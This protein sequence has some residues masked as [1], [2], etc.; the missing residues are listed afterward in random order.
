MHLHILSLT[1]FTVC[2]D[3]TLLSKAEVLVRDIFH[4]A[5]SSMYIYRYWSKTK[6]AKSSQP[7]SFNIKEVEVLL[8]GWNPWNQAN[9]IGFS[10]TGKNP[11]SKELKQ[12]LHFD[13]RQITQRLSSS[14]EEDMMQVVIITNPNLAF[15]CGRVIHH[16]YCNKLDFH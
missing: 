11:N 10:S 7:L 2:T 14:A 9:F 8:Q 1:L 6:A 3:T 5:F 12:I 13:L 15:Q 4:S 16:Y